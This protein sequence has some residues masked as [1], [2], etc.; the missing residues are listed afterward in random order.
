MHLPRP[1]ESA[2]A[3]SRVIDRQASSSITAWENYI[4]GTLS[5]APSENED[6]DSE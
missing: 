6:K 5:T 4:N 1:Y 2:L 3:F